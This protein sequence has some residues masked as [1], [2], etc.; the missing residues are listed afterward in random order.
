MGLDFRIQSLTVALAH[1]CCAADLSNLFS[2]VFT[3]DRAPF[4]I[5]FLQLPIPVL[6]LRKAEV[7]GRGWGQQVMG[8]GIDLNTR[9]CKGVGGSAK[10]KRRVGD[11]SYSDGR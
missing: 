2:T 6:V 9:K 8:N 7:E 10:G 5:P 4:F 1:G 3:Q 11:H